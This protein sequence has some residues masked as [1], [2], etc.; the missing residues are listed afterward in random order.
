MYFYIM[1]IKKVLWYNCLEMQIKLEQGWHTN[2]VGGEHIMIKYFC[3]EETQFPNPLEFPTFF[4]FFDIFCCFEK[5]EGVG[6]LFHF[7]IQKNPKTELR[8]R[9]SPL[10][11]LVLV[12]VLVLVLTCSCSSPA[13]FFDSLAQALAT[14][15]PEKLP[16][17]ALLCANRFLCS[18][19][20]IIDII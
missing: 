9:L 14:V 18:L 11:T 19:A 5:V 16:G 2:T 1:Y 17:N 6:H 13:L 20:Q 7:W 8:R 3:S 15:S 12:L 10:P 4:L